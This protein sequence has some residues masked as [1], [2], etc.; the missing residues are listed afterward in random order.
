MCVE[1]TY[2][3]KAFLE[4]PFSLPPIDQNVDSTSGCDLLSFLDCYFWYHQIQLKEED[5]I[6]ISFIT[7]FGIYCYTTIPFE[8][9]N[10]TATYQREI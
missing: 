10:T 6:K 4:D 8:L 9:K 7:L 2:L 3:N 1:Y 5:Q